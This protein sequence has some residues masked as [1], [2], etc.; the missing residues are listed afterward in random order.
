MTGTMKKRIIGPLAGLL[1]F[2]SLA[3]RATALDSPRELL[4]EVDKPVHLEPDGN[5]MRTGLADLDAFLSNY[6]GVMTQCAL[7]LPLGRHDEFARYLLLRFSPNVDAQIP[8]I[9]AALPHLS[10]VR[11][12]EPNRM[13]RVTFYPNDPLFP[14][15]WGLE[16]VA[17]QDAWDITVGS[18]DVPIAIIDT[19]CEMDH[20]DLVSSFWTNQDEIPD[21][22]L[23]DDGNGFVDDIHGWDFVDA[24]TFP[25]A[26][27]YLIRDND[28]S[29]EMGHGTAVAGICGAA[30]HNDLGIA[31]VAAGCPLMILRAGNMEG[32]LQEDDVASALLY[33]LDNGARVV[34]MSFGDT[35]ASPMLED[36]INYAYQGGL[37]MVTAA[38]NG[39]DTGLIY[40]A[41]FGPTLS[42]GACTE[43]D[44]RASFSSYGNSLDLLAPGTNILSTVLGQAY[45][46]YQGGNG[47]SYSAPFASGVAGLVL[48]LHPQWG[49]QEVI[50][51]LKTSAQ[52]IGPTGWDPESGQGIL[53]ADQAVAIPEALVAEIT[54]PFPSQGFAEAETLQVLGTASG[55]YLKT[56]E[57]FS[58]IGTNPSVWDTVKRSSDV[59]IIDGLLA[60][61]INPEPLDSAYTFR[62]VVQD[63]FGNTIEDRV[64]VFF[65]PSPP[66]ISEITVLPI[67]DADRPSYLLSFKTDDLTT[68]NVWLHGLGLGERWISQQLN[69]Q[70][71]DHIILLGGDLPFKEYEYYIWV[72]N[73]TGLIDSTEIL[74]TIDLT[75]ESMT[76]NYFVQMPSSGIPSSSLFEETTDLDDDGFPEIWLNALDLNGSKSD[77]HVYEATTNWAFNDLDL[78]FGVEIPKSIGDSDADGLMELLT[79]YAGRSKIFEAD[80]ANGFPQPTNVAWMD[81]GDVWGAK[82]LDLDSLDGHGEVIIAS[83]GV[84]KLYNNWGN[85]ELDFIQDL[86]NPFNLAATTLPPYCRLND[87]DADGYPDL[88]FGDYDGHLF[89]YERGDDGLFDVSW[90]YSLPLLDTGEFLTD[91]DYDGDGVDEF[92]ALAHTETTLSGEHMADTRYW[93]LYTFANEGDD[94]YVITDSLYFFGAENPS[95]FPSGINSGNVFGDTLPEILLCLYPDLYV[96]DWVE[97]TENFDVIWYYPQCR[98]NKAVVGD[99]NRN[100]HDEMIFDDGSILRTFEE[101]GDW[102]SGLP[103]PLH[104]EADPE[105][106][107]VNLSWS[108]VSGADGYSLYKGTTSAVSDTIMD[109]DA[110]DSTYTDY[111]VLK[112]STYYYAIATIHLGFL[113]P[114]G[115]MTSPLAATPNDPPFVPGDTAHFTNPNFVSVQFSEAMGP[116]LLDETNYWISN[117]FV[118]PSSV[119]SD[120][121]GSR[122]VLTFDV[123]FKDSTYRL[124]IHELYDLQGSSLS[125]LNDTL[126][127]TVSAEAHALPYLAAAY[128]GVGLQ[129]VTLVFSDAMN[130]TELAAKTNY[131]ITVDPATGVPSGDHI[132][133]DSAEP[134]T[135]LANVVHLY[136]KPSSP[137]GPFGKI[138][139]V[140]AKNLH[141]TAEL[142]IDTTHNVATLTFSTSDLRDV[143]VYPNPY[144]AGMLVDGQACM[145]FAN[146]PSD[147][148]IRILNI[149]GLLVKTIKTTDN[150]MGGVRWYLDNDRGEKIGSGIYIYY[151]TGAGDTFWGKLAVVR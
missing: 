148:E 32:F 34:N 130:T 149:E 87:Y 16:K 7:V 60:L 134:D 17:A 15:Q 93:G 18:A 113:P 54:S 99:F 59:Q 61:W 13:Q 115:P 70:T 62:L 57:V 84:Y 97:S 100:G 106:D 5:R 22:G 108:S 95:D 118:Q 77:L 101:V 90:S 145:I 31:G 72:E 39:G 35:Q 117:S 86:P 150:V 121:G 10:S 56:Y 46:E 122:S 73:S 136:I 137:I 41:A 69:Y 82:L 119:V 26:G 66:E 1:F 132:F 85:G 4:I 58:G 74:G 38:G 3:L 89:I 40:P 144:K 107:R 9:L 96:V 102:S 81:S 91:G 139:R 19:G 51:V 24:P 28:P 12:A 88:L 23:D 65:D 135:I 129:A 50:S 105:P 151:V 98:S 79:L 55:V 110:T 127:F 138:Y 75:I 109:V 112:D 71:T 140:E 111:D 36:V 125:T 68:G 33:A 8:Q 63:L 21:N 103:P 42:V 94:G 124:I 104:F 47:T 52:D 30:M 131:S 120:A 29:D 128:P 48:S 133:I 141:S 147:T 27:D 44:E 116:S 64:E 78:D 123:A 114:E 45:D 143:F 6:P 142:P 53:R 146:L 126:Q 11:W 37:L 76:T 67:L 92:A 2:L 80:G 20:P 43:E 49:P 83:G 14:D 25:T